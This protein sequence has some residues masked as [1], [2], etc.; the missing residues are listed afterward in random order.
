MV[1]PFMN[2]PLNLSSFNDR[3]MT[4]SYNTF[5]DDTSLHFDQLFALS[6][7]C[8]DVPPQDVGM[9]S[10]RNITDI[11]NSPNGRAMTL[12]LPGIYQMSFTTAFSSSFDS[13]RQP[14][15][16]S[17]SSVSL[18]LSQ[19]CLSMASASVESMPAVQSE[20]LPLLPSVMARSSAGRRSNRWTSGWASPAPHSVP[21]RPMSLLSSA[22]NPSGLMSTSHS[23]I[24]ILEKKQIKLDESLKGFKQS[25]GLLQ[26]KQWLQVLHAEMKKTELDIQWERQEYHYKLKMQKL[27]NE[28]HHHWTEMMRVQMQLQA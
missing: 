17:L 14:F 26:N 5:D 13:S 20:A 10:W 7:T 3:S 28:E 22:S 9:S 1:P 15:S 12:P 25:I 19:M 23:D 21:S 6:D 8:I 18:L 16:A 4:H 24:W 27:Q 11:Y 2:D